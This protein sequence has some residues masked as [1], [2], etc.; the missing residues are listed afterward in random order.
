MAEK[1]FDSHLFDVKFDA[2]WKW[3]SQKLWEISDLYGIWSLQ[4]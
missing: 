3:M 4:S 1:S 2:G